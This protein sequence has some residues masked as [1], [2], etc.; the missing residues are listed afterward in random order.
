[1]FL[2]VKKSKIGQARRTAFLLKYRRR[3]ETTMLDW[4]ERLSDLVPS[5]PQPAEPEGAVTV[6]RRFFLSTPAL[7][8]ASFLL[9]RPRKAMAESTFED[10]AKQM[11]QRALPMIKDPN[12]NE[13]EYLFQ[14]ASL[15]ATI[16]QFPP[17]QF[18]EAFKGLLWSSISY[19]GSGIGIIQWRMEPNTSYPAHN[20]PGYSGLSVGI[21]GD[22]RIRNFDYV[23]KPP[24]VASK[25]TFLVRE[26]HDAILREGTIT[27]IMSTSRDNIH[28]LHAGPDGILAA[29]IITKIGPD[30]G[31]SFL[32]IAAKPR[33]AQKG[34]YEAVWSAP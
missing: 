32:N 9:A 7:L 5:A 33:D 27:S 10:V 15:A 14:I 2:H 3:K 34:P 19:R 4:L 8:A 18:G 26:T 13:D 25:E 31:F 1:M 30:A 6:V 28:E 20:H 12:R 29:D 23:G 17:P 11:G 22:C 24:E 16:K 21:R